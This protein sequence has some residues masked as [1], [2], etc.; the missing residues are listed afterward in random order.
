M[1]RKDTAIL[2]RRQ[3]EAATVTELRAA[4]NRFGGAAGARSLALLRAAADGALGDIE[5]LLAYHDVLLFLLAY[6]ATAAM[7][8]LAARELT[9]VAA[10]ARD[11]DTHGPARARNSLRGSGIAWS[12]I[13]IAYGY[14][15]V[16]WLVAR[17][18][19]CVDVDS[20]GERGVLLAEWLRHGLHPAEFELLA[21][22]EESPEALLD[23]G[24]KGWHGSPLAW[25][26]A[27]FERLPC[28]PALR[29]TLYD[30]LE[31][32]VSL[33]PRDAPISRTFARGL[34]CPAFYHRSPLLPGV[35][36][37]RLIA[38][39]L[40]RARRLGRDACQHLVD[41]GRA[42]LAML[43][44]ETDPIAHADIARTRHYH[45]G[46]GVD[47]ALYSATPARRSVLDSHIGYVLFKN[48]VPIGYGGGWPFLGTCKIGINIFPPFRGG[49]SAFL[50]ASVL[51]VYA[52]LFAVERFVVEAYQFGAG[53]REGLESGAFWFYFRLGFRPVEPTLQAVALDEFKRMQRHPGHRT[54]LSVLRRLARSDLELPVISGARNA[55]DP[56]ALSQAVTVWIASRFQGRRDR[57]EAAALR[58][59]AAAL[60]LRDTGG[61]S[62][63][64]RQVLRAMAPV[65]AQ[66]RDLHAWPARHK[67]RLVALIRAKGGNEYRYF[68]LMAGFAHLRNGLNAV[69]E[70][71]AT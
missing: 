5:V 55:C 37:D 34:P 15:I 64:E 31:L 71:S 40:P 22:G 42:A 19:R 24:T 50:M 68:A 44:R 21:S 54:S 32:F 9:R 69:A 63:D 18:P 49:E 61:W 56:V 12:S 70:S 14:S 4:A 10:A 2:P 6:P 25:L 1:G 39:A 41:A 65:L 11:I 59:V 33:N 43:G 36:V 30:S 17:F 51:R 57:A 13:T 60:G 52:Q 3:L 26:I 28:D 35:D 66:I 16:R 67:H 7:R 38:T 47:I 20:F 62:D 53:N 46:R 27:Q 45:L 29:E 58:S 8:S 48:T 23:A